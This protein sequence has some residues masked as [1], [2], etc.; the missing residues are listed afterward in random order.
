M[1]Q[2]STGSR[3]HRNC[4]EFVDRKTSPEYLMFGGI[5]S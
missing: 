2:G 4:R 1:N 5:L 3:V